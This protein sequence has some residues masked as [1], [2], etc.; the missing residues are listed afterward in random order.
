MTG[1]A[2]SKLDEARQLQ[3]LINGVVDYAIYLLE[4]DGTIASWNP[5]GERIKGYAASEVLGRNFSM[6]YTAEDVEE[7]VPQLALRIAAEEGRYEREGWRMR[8]DGTRFWASVV[9][10]PIRDGGQLIG[11][12]KVT[13]DI[14][15]RREAALALQKAQDALMQSQKTE[16]I[17]RLTLGL[18]HDFNNILTVV[19]NSLDRISACGGDV[20]K[21]ARSVDV[22]QRAADRGALLTKQLLAFS[23]G[24]LTR[25]KVQ[26]VN[27]V[28]AASRSLLRRA[29]DA[30]VEIDFD[31]AP[32]LPAAPLDAT[33]FEAAL[34]NLVVNARDAMPDGGHIDVSS[35]LHT[36]PDGVQSIV[37]TVQD[38][39]TG[40]PADVAARAMDPFFTTKEV[41]KGSGLGLSQ[42]YGTV[43]R[44]GGTVAIESEP[45]RGASVIMSFPVTAVPRPMADTSS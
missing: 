23:R 42:V 28:I 25:P 24:D 32:G 35:R 18:A 38:S 34:L 7:R 37:V 22:A 4:P 33:Q 36:A 17:S 20:A 21:I 12:A 8:K 3:I 15:E 13:R 43:S 19:T 1:G 26:D 9:I 41:G 27:A 16:A 39:G 31:L 10:D 2:I 45:G 44:L 40:M 30:T 6:F 11:F 29:C 14:S 5:G